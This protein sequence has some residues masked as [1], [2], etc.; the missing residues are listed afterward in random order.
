M[1]PLMMQLMLMMM[2]MLMTLMMVITMGMMT[3]LVRSSKD[4]ARG[5]VTV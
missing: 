2:M 5:W 1:T 3:A 4:P